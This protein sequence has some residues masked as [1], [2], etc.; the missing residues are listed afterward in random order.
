MKTYCLIDLHNIPGK[1]IDN[2]ILNYCLETLKKEIDDNEI[3]GTLSK[4]LNL[5]KNQ[6]K[7]IMTWKLPCDLDET[8]YKILEEKLW[9]KLVIYYNTLNLKYMSIKKI[10]LNR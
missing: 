3:V 1:S 5:I 7:Y 8:K 9:S 2:N 10:D 4:W 6:K